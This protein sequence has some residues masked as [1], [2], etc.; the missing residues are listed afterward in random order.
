MKLLLPLLTDMFSDAKGATARNKFLLIERKPECQFPLWNYFFPT[1]VTG[2]RK[3]ELWSRM[4]RRKSSLF[5]GKKRKVF[6]FK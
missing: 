5:F 4:I 3:G 1:T 2:V 6:S